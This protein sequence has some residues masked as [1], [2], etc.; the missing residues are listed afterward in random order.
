M[1]QPK[2]EEKKSQ[3]TE[4]RFCSLHG[5]ERLG[6]QDDMASPITP[7]AKIE[8]L[9]NSGETIFNLISISRKTINQ[10]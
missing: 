5:E 10:V 9:Q 8:D 1:A 2:S 6:E 3:G 4:R 7:D